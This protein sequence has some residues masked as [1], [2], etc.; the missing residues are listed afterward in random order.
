MSA[1]W[2]SKVLTIFV[3]EIF[4]SLTASTKR[5]Q[6]YKFQTNNQVPRNNNQTISNYQEPIKP[7]GIGSWDLFGACIL[8]VGYFF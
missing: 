7:S 6:N 2:P 3:R 8:V 1:G 4:W 5:L